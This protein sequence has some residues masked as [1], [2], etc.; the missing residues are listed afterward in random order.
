MDTIN[1]LHY[2]FNDH[3][4]HKI[5]KLTIE[6]FIISLMMRKLLLTSSLN[7]NL[8]NNLIECEF[9]EICKIYIKKDEDNDSYNYATKMEKILW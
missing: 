1:N 2:N 5:N 3:S 9:N 4:N 6:N 8:Q 7:Q